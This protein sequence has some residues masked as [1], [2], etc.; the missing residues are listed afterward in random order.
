MDG[1]HRI[2]RGLLERRA[3]ITALRLRVLP[4]PDYRDCHPDQLPY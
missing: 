2:A 1:M 4:D 3:T